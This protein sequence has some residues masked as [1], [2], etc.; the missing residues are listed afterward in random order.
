MPIN[1]SV[2]ADVIDIRTDS[3]QPTD[4]YL[5][6]TNVWYWLVYT[7][8]SLGSNPPKTWQLT[9]YPGYVNQALANGSRMRQCGLTLSE[10]AHRIEQTERE[11]YGH[12]ISAHPP[13][14]K[15]FRHNFPAERSNVVSEVQTAWTQVTSMASSVDVIVNDAMTAAAV[16]R[17]QTEA[18][19]GYD[20]F[21]LEAA[22][23]SGIFQVITDDG[24]FCGVPGIRMFTSNQAVIAAAALQGRLV[25]R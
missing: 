13:Q 14:T 17:F 4:E 8:A 22:A 11:I 6:D 7:R 19:D 20:L 23:A 3:P 5:V 15:E 16:L 18:L 1:Y 9:A 2:Q 10:L 24:D 12:L 21:L 25:V